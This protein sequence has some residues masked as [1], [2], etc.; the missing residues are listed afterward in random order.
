MDKKKIIAGVAMIIV[1]MTFGVIFGWAVN[2]PW[3][4]N[5][6]KTNFI[7]G[8]VIV[9]SLWVCCRMHFLAFFEKYFGLNKASNFSIFANLAIWQQ[10]RY[11]S[12]QVVALAACV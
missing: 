1:G 3:S 4:A 2:D 8:L 12:L 10:A 5:L 7:Y 11:F 9:G 6:A